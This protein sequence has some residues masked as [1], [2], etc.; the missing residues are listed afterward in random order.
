MKNESLQSE[1]TSKGNL[2]EKDP[3]R[4]EKS[5]QKI[6]KNICKKNTV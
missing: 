2:D 4:E 5:K 3:N 6:E 1:A